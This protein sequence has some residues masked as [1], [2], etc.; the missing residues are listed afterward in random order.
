MMVY[1]SPFYN[2]DML[3]TKDVILV[4]LTSEIS[5]SKLDENTAQVSA[6]ALDVLGLR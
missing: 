6:S 4:S 5:I 2:C 3:E 1:V